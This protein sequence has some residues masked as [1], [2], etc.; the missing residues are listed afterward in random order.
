MLEPTACD[1][2]RPRPEHPCYCQRCDLLVGLAG[3]HVI[4]VSQDAGTVRVVVETPAQQTGCRACGVIA[5]SHGRREVRLVDVPC[6]GRPVTLIW[7]KRTWRCAE[8]KC[9]TKSF[10]E[11]RLDLAGPRALLTVRACWWAI[12]QLR[13]EHASIAGLARQLGTT[14]RTVWRSIQPLLE[15]MSADE[16]RFTDVTSSGSMS[17]SG[18]T[19]PPNPSTRAAAGRRS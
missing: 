2:S 13:G 14:W 19:S 17:T 18:T 16:D 12:T 1:R 15:A 11:Q 3:F 5:H 9:S 6:F 4:D 7:R 8:E 10:T